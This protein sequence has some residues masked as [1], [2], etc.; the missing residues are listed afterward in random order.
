MSRL[1]LAVVTAISFVVVGCINPASSYTVG[2]DFPSE[3]VT[4]IVKGEATSNELVRMFGE[5]FSKMVVSEY[6]EKWT[7]TYSTGVTSAQ[8]YIITMKEKTMGRHKT[9]D[10]LLKNGKVTNFTYNEEG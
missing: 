2:K 1:A 8:S 4:R 10:V 6:E 9:L 5:P 3:N 7:Y